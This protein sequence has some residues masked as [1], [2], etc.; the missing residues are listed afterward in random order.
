MTSNTVVLHHSGSSACQTG[1]DF[2]T[3]ERK[4]L[5]RARERG[6]LDARC[7]NPQKIMEMFG[8]WCWRLKIPM[9]WLERQSPRSKY[10]NVRLELFTTANRLTARGQEVMQAIAITGRA[11]V[12][13]HS[14]G[15]K[16]V[17]LN[18]LEDVAKAVFRAA[19]RT[20]NY[21]FE[22]ASAAQETDPGAQFAASA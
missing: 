20:G 5:D 6:Y 17:P 15:C 1:T 2:G 11:E 16:R 7:R 21:E 9:V 13:A 19:T 3:R 18:R 8:L 10:G 4:R 12:S 14:V 22:R